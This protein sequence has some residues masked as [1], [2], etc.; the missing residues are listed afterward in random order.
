MKFISVLTSFALLAFTV[1]SFAADTAYTALNAV[2]KVKGQA[3]LDNL[4]DLEGLDGSSQPG[5]WRL[6]FEDSTSRGGFREVE[7]RGGEIISQSTP[8]KSPFGS[9]DR[10]NLDHL[11]LDSDG[12]FTLAEREANKEGIS[13]A[14]ANY[15]LQA[16]SGKPVWRVQLLNSGGNVVQTLRIS[17]KTGD[18]IGGHTRPTSPVADSDYVNPEP[19]TASNSEIDPD[20][21]A[22]LEPDGPNDSTE[23]KIHRSAIR[24]R[25]KI[26][27]SFKH[28][29]GSVE[30][31]FTG[32]RTI[33]KDLPGE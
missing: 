31:I 14:T 29:G 21:R 18:V 6:I 33:D 17:A 10:V 23:L 27:N 30:E 26:K 12:A 28:L 13:F 4:L 7:V 15:L 22:A 11:Q 24:A 8:L 16:D 20:D 2:G 9:S 19:Q 25:L 5:T 1:S 32:K 3:Y